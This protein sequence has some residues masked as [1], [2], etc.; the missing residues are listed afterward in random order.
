[1]PKIDANTAR[2]MVWN[3]LLKVARPDSR[4]SFDFNE[5]ITDYE[6]SEKCAELLCGQQFYKDARVIFITPDNNLERLRE[7]AIRD[8]KIILITNYGITRGVFL[9]RPEWVPPGK[10]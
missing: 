4:F 5:F 6:G 10:E 9:L 7:Q 8:K 3:E 2:L 1:M